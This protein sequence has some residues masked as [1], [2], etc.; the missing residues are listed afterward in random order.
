MHASTS[1]PSHC[2]T[3]SPPSQSNDGSGQADCEY[4]GRASGSNATGSRQFLPAFLQ[5][6]ILCRPVRTPGTYPHWCCLHAPDQASHVNHSLQIPL[7]ALQ[8]PGS[9]YIVLQLINSV[10]EIPSPINIPLPL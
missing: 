9:Q 4:L 8:K 5:S 7:P 6:L 3:P 1:T 10:V 2:S